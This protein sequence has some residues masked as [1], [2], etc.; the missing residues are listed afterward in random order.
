MEQKKQEGIKTK[1]YLTAIYKIE[2]F[3][4][5]SVITAFIASPITSLNPLLAAGWFAGLVEA[6]VRKPRVIDLENLSDDMSSFKKMMNNRFIRIL[7]VVIVANLFSSI[8]TY[9]SGFDIIKNL[10][11]SL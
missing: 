6:Y 2:T 1:S 8:A 3:H 9:I 10:L 5:L 7:L 4:P 11:N